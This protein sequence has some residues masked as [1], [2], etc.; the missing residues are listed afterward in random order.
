MD[1]STKLFGAMVGVTDAA[2]TTGTYH[3]VSEIKEVDLIGVIKDATAEDIA[4]TVIARKAKVNGFTYTYSV[5]GDA[6]EEYTLQSTDKRWFKYDVVVDKFPGK[7]SQPYTYTLSQTPITL[8]NGNR[9]VA[10]KINGE[11]QTEVASS[12]T[13]GQYSVSGTTLTLGQSQAA[14]DSVVAVYHANVAGNNWADITDNT[15]PA[16]IRGKNI[17]VKIA[18]NA[19]ER[20][21]SVTIRGTFPTTA[22]REMGNTEVV[23]YITAPTTV[24]GDISVLD[25]DLELMALFTTGS[26]NP[27]D[28]EFRACEF[29]AS[30][31]S[32]E[33]NIYDPTTDCNLPL[34]SGTI[35][36]TLYIPSLTIT[37]EGHSTSVGGNAT[38]TFGF[39]STTGELRIYKG[40]R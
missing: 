4:K 6:T 37:S 38:Q 13:A 33:I 7:T 14:G 9:L 18:A 36:K 19:I 34:A 39:R 30:G 1:V 20:V 5:D 15:I 24:E 35:L 32:L 11:Y 22:V 31:I 23:G 28:V 10:V 3:D 40:A 8:K 12:P 29:T 16:A 27:A 26:T 17:P 2:W 21:Q 25:T